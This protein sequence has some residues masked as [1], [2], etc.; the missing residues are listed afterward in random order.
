MTT[1]EREPD[2]LPDDARAWLD[3]YRVAWSMPRSSFVRVGRAIAPR[4][5]TERTAWIVAAVLVAAVLLLVIGSRLFTGREVVADATGPHAL[6]EDRAKPASTEHATTRAPE[7]IPAELPPVASTPIT[8]TTPTP[9]PPPTTR[10][11]PTR[12]PSDA[13]AIA[14]PSTPSLSAERELLQPA[15]DA[16]AEGDG[17]RAKA[18]AQR[19]R[20]E[21]P[22]GQL[23]DVREA[24][25]ALVR[26]AA[27]PATNR[28]AIV[29]AF[30]RAHPASTVLG[31]VRSGCTA[32]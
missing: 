2:A 25:D 23:S 19:H 6:A 24:I 22:T 31:R 5:S 15:W 1:G 16:L 21:F 32:D 20:T 27:A 13:A 26:C 14:P 30:E 11:E 10:T 4:R 9:P 7:S 3:D 12:V 17:K 28:P 29:A 8:Q 18:I